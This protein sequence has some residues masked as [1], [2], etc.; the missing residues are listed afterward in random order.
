MRQLRETFLSLKDKHFV[1]FNGPAA[2]YDL[3]FIARCLSES[4]AESAG[5]TERGDRSLSVF[6]CLPNT[7]S[8]S[9]RG[10]SSTDVMPSLAAVLAC[11]TGSACHAAPPPT[12]ASS[13]H[14]GIDLDQQ[15]TSVARDVLSGAGKTEMVHKASDVLLAMGVP[16]EFALG[17]LR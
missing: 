11:S 8:L 3:P 13:V 12:P 2:A 9:F 14:V 4:Q 15:S 1:A 17:T 7:V 5:E 6:P 16:L 10:V